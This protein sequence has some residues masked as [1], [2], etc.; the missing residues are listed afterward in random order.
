MTALKRSQRQKRADIISSLLLRRGATLSNLTASRVLF[1][2]L[3]TAWI[4]MD[5]LWLAVVVG[6]QVFVR[7]NVVYGTGATFG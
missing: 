6:I 3:L 7:C 2:V 1:G 4:T 5:V